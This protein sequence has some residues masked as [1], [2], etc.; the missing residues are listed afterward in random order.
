MP[1]RPGMID[2]RQRQANRCRRTIL[3]NDDHFGYRD[4]VNCP[5][6]GVTRLMILTAG[7]HRRVLPV[8]ECSPGHP[9]LFRTVDC[10]I[11]VF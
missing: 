9:R 6:P 7:S 2:E 5:M 10:A 11:V 4:P 8:L 3:I 1:G